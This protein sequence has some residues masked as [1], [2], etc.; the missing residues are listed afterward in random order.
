[1]QL[2]IIN[3]KLKIIFEEEC[4]QHIS[5]VAYYNYKM[6]AGT[7]HGNIYGVKLAFHGFYVYVQTVDQAK[8]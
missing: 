6:A 5:V 1:M 8:T 4:E 7:L 3:E 2:L